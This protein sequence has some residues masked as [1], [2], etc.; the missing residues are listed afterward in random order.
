M[1]RVNHSTAHRAVRLAIALAMAGSLIAIGQ[2]SAVASNREAG[3][4]NASLPTIQWPGMVGLSGW[5]PR[6][7]ISGCLAAVGILPAYATF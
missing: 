4:S 3:A 2:P 7:R 1:S 5:F 6:T